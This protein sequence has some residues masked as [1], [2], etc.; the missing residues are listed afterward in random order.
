MD[1]KHFNLSLRE[2]LVTANMSPLV[3]GL[4]SEEA[5]YEIMRNDLFNHQKLEVFTII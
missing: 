4:L 2:K 1:E 3:G 5:L